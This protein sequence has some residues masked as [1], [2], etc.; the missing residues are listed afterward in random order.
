MMACAECGLGHCICGP[1]VFDPPPDPYGRQAALT[2]KGADAVEWLKAGVAIGKEDALAAA[3][4]VV[5]L[6]GEACVGS[7]VLPDGEYLFFPVQP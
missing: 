6:N 2:P 4:K 5:V 1:R 3:I 7:D